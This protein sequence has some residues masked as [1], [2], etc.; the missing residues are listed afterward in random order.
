MEQNT[1]VAP[2][3]QNVLRAI[4]LS[5]GG[6]IFACADGTRFCWGREMTEDVDVEMARICLELDQDA[7]YVGWADTTASAPSSVAIVYRERSAVEIVDGVVPYCMGTQ[8]PLVL[9]DVERKE[10]YAI[11]PRGSLTRRRGLPPRIEAGL[12]F[13]ARRIEALAAAMSDEVRDDN[14]LIPPA[15]AVV[16]DE[17]F[18]IYNRFL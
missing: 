17:D 8:L 10:H 5:M 9:L 15:G 1:V 18:S 3:Q 12:A 13:A 4:R 11:D 6:P 16:A 7:V 14:I 2:H